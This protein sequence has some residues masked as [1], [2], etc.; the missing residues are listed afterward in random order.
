MAIEVAGASGA[1][2]TTAI[3]AESLVTSAYAGATFVLHTTTAVLGPTINLAR[4]RGSAL[5]AVT[6]VQ[7]GDGLG[8]LRWSGA[9]GTDIRSGAAEIFAAV[10]GT[11][12]SNDMPGRLVFGTTA[13]GAATPTERMRIDSLGRLLV[14][15]GTSRDLSGIAG[16]QLEGTN[17]NADALSL[18]HNSANAEG[19]VLAFGKSRGSATGAV[20]IVQS[21]DTLGRLLFFGAD[22]VDMSPWAAEISAIVDGSP[23]SNDM[24]GRIVFSTTA[25]GS[26]IPT[27][28]MRITS[29]G[30]LAIGTTTPDPSAKLDVASTTQGFLPPRMTTAQRD[31]IASAALGLT[32]YATD[33]DQLC[34]K[35]VAGWYCFP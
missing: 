11:P 30:N 3:H 32:I 18:I 29:S 13:D 17:V 14:G 16:H 1:G 34:F 20:T 5:G 35:R 8:G 24:P 12:G 27:E 10:D 7:S 28:R 9:D 25:D 19:Q 22:G 33:T 6:I 31:A 2:G 15:S 26:A 23:G 4:T 21:G